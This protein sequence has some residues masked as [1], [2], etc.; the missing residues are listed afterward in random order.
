MSMKRISE[1]DDEALAPTR[2]KHHRAQ[3]RVEAKWGEY[4][5]DLEADDQL[6]SPGCY[7]MLLRKHHSKFSRHR[8]K[9]LFNLHA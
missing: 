6:L 7:L 2:L 9:A 4:L 5:D 8:T 1:E 3:P